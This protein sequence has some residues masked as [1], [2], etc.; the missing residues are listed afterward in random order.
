MNISQ[1]QR[2]AYLRDKGESYRKIAS[3]LDISEN[4][5]KSYCRR[6]NLG[7]VLAVDETKIE[8]KC[9]QCGKLLQHIS[10]SKQ[11]R[12]CSDSCRMAWWK[13]HPEVV[14]RKAVYY[15]VCLFCGT[16][17]TSYGNAHRK[18]CSRACFGLATRRA[19]HE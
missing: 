5:I 11:K 4:T 13:A 8:D 18:Y 10:G 12:F 7:G 9:K 3:T 16:K 6:N 2:I 1:K 19:E 15:F 14:N 17:F